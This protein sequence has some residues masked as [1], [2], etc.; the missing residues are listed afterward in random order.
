[1]PIYTYKGMTFTEE[2][3]TSK[4]EEK[5][6]DLDTYINKFG[7]K[8]EGEEELETTVEEEPIVNKKSKPAKSKK[9]SSTSQDNLF[10]ETKVIDPLNLQKLVNPKK[11]ILAERLS[12]WNKKD[13]TKKEIVGPKDKDYGNLYVKDQGKIGDYLTSTLR[14]EKAKGDFFEVEEEEGKQTLEKLY[15]G[16]PGLTFEET[17]ATSGDISNMFDA[18]KAVYI[19]P[20]TK[21]RKES[22]IL[23]FDIGVMNAKASDRPKLANNNADIL[24]DFFNNNL[25]NVN[26]AK[27]KALRDEAKLLYNKELN[28]SITPE[29]KAE[30]NAEF[31]APDLFTPRKESY[32][33]TNL[34]GGMT[35][36]TAG[37]GSYIVKPYENELNTAKKMVLADP[38]IPKEKVNIEAEKL[39]R[40]MLKTN[41]FNN[42]KALYAESIIADDR[43]L[44]AKLYVGSLTANEEDVRVQNVTS[45][46]KAVAEEKA[47]KL[48]GIGKDVASILQGDY[49]TEEEATAIFNKFKSVGI[50][51]DVNDTE[52]L[53]LKNGNTI[54]R[55]FYNAYSKLEEVAKANEAYY[56]QVSKEQTN[57]LQKLS[58]SDIFSTAAAK[59]Y[60]LSEKYLTNIGA[61]LSDIIV[62]ASYFSAKVLSAVTPFA[63]A[64]DE[65]SQL[66]YGDEAQ[67]TSGK[68][69]EW[70]VN[71]TTAV[72]DIRK[73]YVRDVSFEDAF[74]SGGNFGKFAAQ[75]ISQQIP[76]LIAMAATGGAAGVA[77]VSGSAASTA[78]IGAFGAGGKM[79]QMQTEMAKGEADYS[80]TEV[81]LKSVGFGATEALF[82]RMTT[83]P[84]L[85]RASGHFSRFG[86]EDVLD[87][88]MR[89]YF[90]SKTPGFVFDQ[91]L[92]SAGETG[93]AI[94][95]NIIDGRPVMEN[96]AHAGFSG[97]GM[98]TVM[99]GVPYTHGLYLSAFSDYNSKKD[100][101]NLHLELKDL[102]KQFELTKKRAPKK[103]IAGLMDAKQ[104]EIN[105]AIE[106][107]QSKINE[108]LRAKSAQAI[109]SIES[110]KAKL[111]NEAK[112]IVDDKSIDDGLKEMLIKDLRTKFNGLNSIK[113]NALNPMNLMQDKSKFILLEADSPDRYNTLIDQATASLSK[114]GVVT[115][116]IIKKEAYNLYLKEE[117]NINIDN[118]GKVEGA[119]L[120]AYETG[121]E[122]IAAA[123]KDAD[124]RKA[125]NVQKIEAINNN[126]DLS[127]A[128]KASGVKKLEDANNGIDDDFMSISA[129]ITAGADGYKNNSGIQVVVKDN[130]LENQRTQIATHE[131]GHYVF[132]KIFLN[133][134]K[135][136]VPIANQLLLTTK[137]LDKKLYDKLIKNTE[138]DANGNFLATEVISRFLESVS[139]G[140]IS[141]AEK[142]NSF[143]SGLFGSMVQKE[144]IDQYDF[145]FKGQTD[146]FNFVV[147]LGKKIKSGELT[148]K[149]I[150]GA[151]K[152]AVVK[153][154]VA[155]AEKNVYSKLV[156]GTE[157]ATAFSKS[158]VEL[159]KQK[160]IDLEE[161]EGDY[162]PDEYDQEVA[163]LEG[164]L[165]RAIA[166]EATAPVAK[167][168]VTEE[169][170][171]AQIIKENKGTVSSD[172]VQQIY[173]EKGF[174]GA[175]EIIKLFKP[176]TNK[177]VD[178]RKNAPGFN[179]DLFR[180]EVE[181]GVGGILDLIKSYNGSI[182]LAAWI[183]KYL[184][185]R[186]IATSRRLLD[187]QFSKDASEEKGLMATETADQG[188]TEAAKEKPK[189][190]NALEAKVFPTEVLETATKKIIT[191][192]RTLKTRI[193]APVSLNK[194]VT[195]LISEI[196]DEVGKQLDIDIKTM[197]GGKKDG[198]LVKELL[199]TK[200][201][202]L[203]NM[204]TTW[205]M[206][207]DGQGGIPM[208]IQKQID[209]KWVNFP[210]WVGKKI[211]R[212][213]TTTDQAGRTSGAELV[214]RLPN[215]ANNIS[216]EVFLA[217]IIGPDGNPIRGRKESLSKAMSEEGAF[218]IINADLAEEGPIFEALATNQERLGYEM[219]NNFA[220]TFS[221]QSE[222]GNVKFSKAMKDAQD[223]F[224]KLDKNVKFNLIGAN[225]SNFT[226]FI[227]NVNN[228]DEV[229]SLFNIAYEDISFEAEDR[230]KIVNA[231]KGIYSFYKNQSGKSTA[232]TYG[233]KLNED[234]ESF[235]NRKI[236]NALSKDQSLALTVNI[237]T[238]DLKW[239]SK[240]ERQAARK[241]MKNF[242]NSAIKNFTKNKKMSKSEAQKL[243]TRL[244]SRAF[245]YGKDQSLFDNQEGFFNAF[246]NKQPGFTMGAGEIR[247]RTIKYNG[248]KVNSNIG[249]YGQATSAKDISEFI[250]TGDT[251]KIN[252]KERKAISAAAKKDLKTLVTALK[253]MYENEQVNDIQLGL[254]FK[255]L[256]GSMNSP[257]KLASEL[258]YVAEKRNYS[259]NTKEW[260]YEH[261]PPSSYISRIALGIITGKTKTTIDEFMD[262]LVN[263]S[264]VT[265]LPKSFDKSVNELYKSNMPFYYEIGDNP[266]IRYLDAGFNGKETPAFYD[267]YDKKPINNAIVKDA[268]S[269][270]IIKDT[271]E[272]VTKS[273]FF[274]KA[275][276]GISV[277]DFDDTVGLTSGSVLYT[278]P[279]GTK[280]KLNAEEFAKEGSSILEAGGVFDFSEFSKV[281]DG[282]PGPM[283]EKMKKMI[284]KFGPENFFI[285]TARPANAAGP[286]HEFLSSIGIDIPLENITGLGSSLA[287]SKA[288]WMTAKA[289]EG[290]NDFYFADDAIQNVEAVKKALDIPGVDSKV[291]QA[292]VKFS[293]TSKQDLKWRQSDEDLST[294]FK[295]GSNSYRIALREIGSM[296]YDDDINNALLNIVENNNL[297]YDKT[298]GDIDGNAYDVEFS[299]KKRGTGITGTGNAAEVFGTVLN[300]VIDLANKR[301]IKAFTFNAK[302][303]SR[304]KLYNSMTNIIADRLGWDSKAENGTYLLYD[305]SLIGSTKEKPKAATTEIPN[306][307]SWIDGNNG[308]FYEKNIKAGNSELRLLIKN[309]DVKVDFD[310]DAE[311]SDENFVQ[312]IKEN[313]LNP[314]NFKYVFAPQNTKQF[315]F[316]NSNKELE[317][318][319]KNDISS[320]SNAI[321][322]FVNGNNIK[323]ITLSSDN[324][325]D[326]NKNIDNLFK[327]IATNVS[328]DLNFN[329]YS[330]EG[331]FILTEKEATIGSEKGIGSL[332]QVKDVLNV[333]DIKSTINQ[334]KVKFSKTIS[335]EFNKIIE[336]NKGME[337]YK[338]FSD[339]VARRRGKSKN[340][341]D[342]YVPPSAADFELLLYNF[343]GKG[344]RGEEQQR[345]FN[346][347]LLKPYANGNDLMDAARQSIKKDYKALLDSFPDIRKKMETLTPDGDYTYDQAI[348]VAMWNE[349]GVEIP[350]ISE[351][352]SRKLTDLVNNDPEL[353]AFK[354]GL[355]VTGRQGKGW[356]NPTEYW[357]ANTIIADLHGLTEGEGRKKFLAEFIDNAEQMFGTWSQGKLVGP[358]INKVEA[359]YGT[360][361]REAIEDVLYRMTTG[362]NRS[363]GKDKETS[364]WSN[365]VN[366]STGAIMFLNTR[367]AALQL[368]GAVNFLNL[369]DNNPFNAGAAFLNQPQ[370]WKDFSLIWNSDKMKERRG[371]LKEDVAAAEIAS[372]AAGSKNKPAAVIAYLLK[373][374]YTPTQLADSFA[375]AS[376][377]APF[378]RNR[379]KSYLKEGQMQ[380]EAEAN[381]WNDFTKVS[382]ETQQ[383][384]DPR[385]I[386]KQQ[387]SGAGR[388]L[389]TFQNTAMQQSRIVKKS[390][391]DLRAG[392]GNAKTHISKIVY[393]LA[394]QNTLF[395][396]LQQGLFA[397]AFDDDDEEKD[398]E[399]EKAKKKKTNE[400]LIDVADGVLDTILRG[401]GFVGGVISVL[402]NMTNKYLDERDKNFKADYAKVMLE[403]ANISPP[404]GSKLRKLYTGLQQ[405][406]FEK[407]LI[408]ERGWDI[409]QDGRVHLGPMYGVTGKLVEATTNLPMDRLVNKIENISQAMN[410][411]NQAWQ[412]VAVGVGFTPYSVGIEES[413]GDEKI[414]AKAKETRAV[415][416]KVKA[417]DTRERKKDSILNLPTDE[418]LQYV[419]KRKAEKLGKKDSIANL[420]PPEKVEYN[421]SKE[422]SK[423]L[424]EKE[425]T[426]LEGIRRDSIA[427]LTPEEKINYN[428]K[429]AA[430]KLIKKKAS[431]EKYLEKKKELADS[432]AGLTPKQREKYKAD[433]KAERHQ[434]YME[435]K[436]ADA[437]K[438]KKKK[439]T[440][441]QF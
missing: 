6:L 399:K 272:A 312:L 67:T 415:E 261:V 226:N 121:K 231:I 199:R 335:T 99:S 136:F 116:E 254:I 149:E 150:K 251:S 392:R 197:L 293:L 217:Q 171:V 353:A 8:R 262:K 406:K 12:K 209:G 124:A 45:V 86:G 28:N 103:A 13:K 139:S 30:V 128:K 316:I 58:D 155:L 370:Y 322:E 132:D 245:S 298:I 221:Q 77:G 414:R 196:R 340:K 434:Y 33:G 277:F 247:G 396:V 84:I 381:A 207:K 215:V 268:F 285:L 205:L 66:I 133:N 81:W 11:D 43:S 252:I 376:G 383:S 426:T 292:M 206:G 212:E 274:S 269:S 185:R 365:W 48:Q 126:Q 18:V 222:R 179:E 233:I 145:D 152:G 408:K 337:H 427:M 309:A 357:D 395:A 308:R 202:V 122:A 92:E 239:K 105:V 79:S 379:I 284:A 26:L 314:E 181:T 200:R 69:D 95:Q 386:S 371:G 213:K 420:S 424:K 411:E 110:E 237:P 235:A 135:A 211:D 157:T 160:L 191:I 82:E 104:Q 127:D 320:I 232:K 216:D 236:F 278:M 223:V 49:K 412:R 329:L 255:S 52:L 229:E 416:G 246:L 332:S 19:D 148:K 360:N 362:K 394:V 243:F 313:N 327:T 25:K 72:D 134:E 435:H 94:T 242:Y 402:K 372:A 1:M 158:P 401:T 71:Y 391:L 300:G 98:G 61:G 144:F 374:G 267:L 385:D 23:K 275:P 64:G 349:E 162:D 32:R 382:D 106:K 123:K 352:D 336:E 390:Y 194:T 305:K 273:L 294:N 78:M 253:E 41:A 147:G 270:K 377:G 114:S 224:E 315:V 165:K 146:M 346:E 323:T 310:W 297:D 184:P 85:K 44:N 351:R 441:F 173:K 169:D 55:G 250:K 405:T 201:Y 137:K 91:F 393:Y 183:N 355:I 138:Q 368:I 306:N 295:V 363:S 433:K 304:I 302:E 326:G 163:K 290:Y 5:G 423:K 260:I 240:T 47:L 282:K 403:G 380:D 141:F 265:I 431:H 151:S 311:L 168:E 175:D 430:E 65:I 204:T 153:A 37:G 369:R 389:L 422:L 170:E 339:I 3:V 208:A 10:G 287:Q 39:A 161:N 388:L 107:Q 317:N 238:S 109:I 440:V 117:I 219:A 248:E 418:Y 4:A 156:T 40:E 38:K 119:Q 27:N 361:V 331:S 76:I 113:E 203:E 176:I 190:K 289:A 218:D 347:A 410:S 299:D 75:E 24:K 53:T 359:V 397:V 429:V 279:D 303:P 101:R 35:M 118:A 96:V 419:L 438:R 241:H 366:G 54:T 409:M 378:Y 358:N 188:F 276:K 46:K 189:Y 345:F 182:P 93:T 70:A 234:F 334:S 129:N 220:A 159:V 83:I 193:D 9:P 2:E 22:D 88:S 307:S 428:K 271:Q 432:L 90:K 321:N 29:F 256:G 74:S 281:V 192:T 20:V 15:A 319:P 439:S 437:A 174:N 413:K 68:L 264:Y 125:A 263:N 154:A 130:M 60:D 166:K 318:I 404:I 21:I 102:G 210:D 425:K 338:V 325:S 333:V 31:D 301:N 384:G 280:G 57:N 167:K 16:I 417:K 42:K 375:I 34:A 186:A 324:I 59:N 259:S 115:D 56:L 63:Y 140:D 249:E 177:I 328:K 214:R 348:R 111:Q 172:K 344:E 178:K 230:N 288:D 87:T 373:I 407:D 80:N 73:S 354:Q 50:D 342:F 36:G 143:L 89:N 97:F 291:Q 398:K 421:K 228:E 195:P 296:E 343:L 187:K 341:F 7:I 17:N 258:R 244:F 257:L 283:V 225:G 108:N 266:L 164:E 227:R 100:I 286:I 51:M 142:K 330:K 387:A 400:K 364:A 436:G 112:S 62:G 198:V 180:D 350:G 131:V 356:I 14:T 120:E 367:S